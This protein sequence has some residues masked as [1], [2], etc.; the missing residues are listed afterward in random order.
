MRETR[1]YGITL[2][3][4]EKRRGSVSSVKV[5]TV[6][7]YSAEDQAKGAGLLKFTTTREVTGRDTARALARTLHVAR[8][9]I[10][11]PTSTLA[12]LAPI[13]RVVGSILA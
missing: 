7:R 11:S 3:A 10:P 13:D 1:Y 4:I 12:A 6:H 8:L 9:S 2:G 5:G